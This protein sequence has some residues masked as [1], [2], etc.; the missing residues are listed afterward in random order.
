MINQYHQI[1]RFNLLKDFRKY[2]ISNK[3]MRNS[4]IDYGNPDWRDYLLNQNQR[5][6]KLTRDGKIIKHLIDNAKKI[7]IIRNIRDTCKSIC[8][9]GTRIEINNGLIYRSSLFHQLDMIDDDGD[10][11]DKRHIQ[12]ILDKRE[13]KKRKYDIPNNTKGI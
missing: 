2:M 8:R 12:Q 9:C 3:T 1:K 11:V 13:R 4:Y 7:V 5:T 10:V 6:H